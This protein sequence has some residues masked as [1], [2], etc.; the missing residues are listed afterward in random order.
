MIALSTF[1][2][3]KQTE[4][5]IERISQILDAGFTAIELD[6]YLAHKTVTEIC[7]FLEERYR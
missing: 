4:N 3:P 5:G 7:L 2:N 6:C 1:G